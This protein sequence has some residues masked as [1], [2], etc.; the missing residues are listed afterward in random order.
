VNLDVLISTMNISSIKELSQGYFWLQKHC[1]PIVLINQC[2]KVKP[3]LIVKKNNLLIISEKSIGLSKSRNLAIKNSQKEICHI[4]DDDIRYVKNFDII[5]ETAYSNNPKADIIVFQIK[6]QD[7][8]KYKN[9]YP[10]KKWIGIMGVAKVSS[11]EITFKRRSILSTKLKFDEKFGLGTDFP[12]GEEFIFLTDAIKKGLKILYIPKPIVIH[13]FESSGKNL[14]NRK[15]VEAKG[16]MFFRVFGIFGYLYLIL[17]SLKKHNQSY[18]G[19]LNLMK[20]MINGIKKYRQ[21]EK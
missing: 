2:T 10:N 20:Y 11:V 1:I 5:I 21:S 18:F 13:T 17:F 9:Y 15:L 16:A 14:N 4:S 7:D 19:L 12:S 3:T 8:L 6:T